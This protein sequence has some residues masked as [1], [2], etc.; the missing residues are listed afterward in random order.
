MIQKI[1]T[2]KR[3]LIEEGDSFIESENEEIINFIKK[4]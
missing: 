1:V 3:N 4:N 2:N